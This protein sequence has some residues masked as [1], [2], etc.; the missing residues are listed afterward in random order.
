MRSGLTT[1][2][3]C[4][5]GA[6]LMETVVALAILATVAVTFLSG[7]AGTSKAALMG[8]ELATA[9]SLAQSQMEWVQSTNYSSQYSPAPIP[10]SQDYTSYNATIAVSNVTGG[11][12]NIQKI[13]V[14]VQHSA[15]TVITLEGY[16]VNR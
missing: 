16:K 2:I 1:F 13:T 14:T 5:S 11:D 6:T 12:A 3:R 7:L 15:K 10:S 8:D 4:E 9:E